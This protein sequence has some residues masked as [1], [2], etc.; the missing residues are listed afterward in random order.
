MREP[1]RWIGQAAFHAAVAAVVGLLAAWPSYSQ[2]P[3]DKAQIK[4]SLSHG[5]QR[6]EACRRRTAEEIAK[7]DPRER[8]PNDCSRQRLPVHVQL[9]VDGELLYDAAIAPSGI[10]GDGPARVYRKLMVAPGQREIVARLRDSDRATGFD[11]ETRAMVTLLPQQSLAVDF[12]S[13]IGGFI[14]R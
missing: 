11:Y 6:V 1:L 13:D 12:R 8:R 5:A 2:F 3:D 7:L 4:L 10:A 14:L 9:V